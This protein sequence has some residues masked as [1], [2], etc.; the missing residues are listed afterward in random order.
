MRVD[1]CGCTVCY[2]HEEVEMKDNRGI[3]PEFGAGQGKEDWLRRKLNAVV[4]HLRDI[5][6]YNR[7]WDYPAEQY[8]G[9]FEEAQA[10]RARSI[11]EQITSDFFEGKLGEPTMKQQLEEAK[12]KI[13]E[14]EASDGY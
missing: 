5:E 8:E 1:A 7:I 14:Q 11:Y 10:D 6:D 13:L 2:E 3:R 4:R 12:A 9:S